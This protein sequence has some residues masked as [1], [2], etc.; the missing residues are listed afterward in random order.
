MVFISV[1]VQETSNMAMQWAKRPFVLLLFFFL[2]LL[3]FLL[4]LFFHFFVFFIF[5]LFLLYFLFLHFFLFP[6]FLIF[7]LLFLPLLYLF[8]ILFHFIMNGSYI[9]SSNTDHI[10]SLVSQLHLIVFRFLPPLRSTFSIRQALRSETLD[11]TA[12]ISKV[13]KLPMEENYFL[14]PRKVTYF[15][16]PNDV[17]Q[18][19]PWF[20]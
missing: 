9:S 12:S 3:H 8:S 10:S 15:P 6:L 4:F 7:F 13:K 19:R 2:C 20:R 18:K 1:S 14:F 17:M 5:F 11:L 16:V